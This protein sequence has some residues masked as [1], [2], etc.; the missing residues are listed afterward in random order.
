MISKNKHI[1][2]LGTSLNPERTMWDANILLII[3]ETPGIDF[4]LE[5]IK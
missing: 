2:M 4:S 3:I 1:K 5:R